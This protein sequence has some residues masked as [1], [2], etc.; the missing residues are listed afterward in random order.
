LHLGDATGDGAGDLGGDF[1]L[2]GVVFELGD[3]VED[4]VADLE[5]D[6]GIL[7]LEDGEGF[8][9]E[10][11]AAGEHNATVQRERLGEPHSDFKLG[12]G[13]KDGHSSIRKWSFAG[14]QRSSTDV[15]G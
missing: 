11:P 10:D 8:F 4:R 12:T 13:D 3:G 7:L 5:G 15:V 1:A 6:G 14:A 9:V 2:A